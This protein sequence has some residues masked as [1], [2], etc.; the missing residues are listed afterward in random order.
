LKVLGEGGASLEAIDAIMK[1]G[2]FR[3][4]P[5]E[6]MDLIGIDVNFAVTQ[7]VYQAFF[8]E[9]RFR[10]H[11]LQ[12]RM[13][14]S[15][16]LGRKSNQG[17]YSY[18]ATEPAGPALLPNDGV[19]R[20]Y[21]VAGGP[22][23]LASWGRAIAAA[24]HDALL[25]DTSI[26]TLHAGLWPDFTDVDGA[27]EVGPTDRQAMQQ[28]LA[29]RLPREAFIATTDLTRTA[30]AAM[31]DHGRPA[32][33]IGDWAG[34]GKLWE[35]AISEGADPRAALGALGLPL[36][37]VTDHPGLVFARVI[38][39]LANEACFALQ[40]GVAGGADI[41]AA[42]RL[43]ANYPRGPLEWA[44]AIGPANVVA[45]LDALC[46][47]LGEE[48]YR[49]APLLRRRAQAGRS[50]REPELAASRS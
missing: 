4:G 14:A 6:L 21:V 40:E 29:E 42:L 1:A 16:R 27:L 12:Q 28:L 46:S 24:G 10:P 3:M 20:R 2:G 17:F 5:F 31:A 45:L 43:G 49:V 9:A 34:E 11:P 19:K 13:V 44:D 47:G 8:G 39:M 50:L 37:E 22:P 41:D 48:R 33:V 25:I 38:S 18:P 26:S 30:T 36:V 15:G 7:S 32:A 23:A 35:V